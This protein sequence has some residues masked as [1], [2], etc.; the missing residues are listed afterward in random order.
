MYSKQSQAGVPYLIQTG[1][2]N[3]G[4]QLR[5]SRKPLLLLRLFGLLLLRLAERMLS[6]LLFQEPPRKTRFEPLFPLPYLFLREFIQPPNI[7]PTSDV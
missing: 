5:T 3:I 4:P 6:A 2:G 1:S 7:L